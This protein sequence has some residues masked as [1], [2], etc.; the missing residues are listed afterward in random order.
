MS[1]AY[2]IEVQET[3]DPYVQMAEEA[4]G[5]A[6]ACLKTGAYLVDMFPIS[7]ATFTTL[8]VF[9]TTFCSEIHPCVDA[10]C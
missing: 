5:G 3:N 6:A 8:N 4:L 2:G 1:M 9:S 10:W 7:E